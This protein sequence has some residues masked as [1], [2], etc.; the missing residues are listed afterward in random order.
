VYSDRT[1]AKIKILKKERERE[2][3]SLLLPPPPSSSR[4]SPESRRPV[5]K[6]VQEARRPVQEAPRVNEAHQRGTAVRGTEVPR[7]TTVRGT[8]VPRGTA[9]RG[10]EVPTGTAVNTARTAKTR[11]RSKLQRSTRFINEVAN[12]PGHRQQKLTQT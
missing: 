3:S 8:E 5:Q 9:V 12:V 11:S 10:T 2:T 7:G 1:V 4:R 6:P